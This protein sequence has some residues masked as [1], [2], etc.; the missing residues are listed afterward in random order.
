MAINISL[1]L[2]FRAGRGIL[3]RQLLLE[4]FLLSIMGWLAG[5]MV[6]IC[7]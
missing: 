2:Y 7:E 1:R 4:N 6:G 3:V 5:V